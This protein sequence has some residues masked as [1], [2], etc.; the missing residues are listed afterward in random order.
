MVGMHVYPKVLPHYH[1]KVPDEFWTQHGY[2][3]E[4]TDGTNIRFMLYDER[5]TYSDVVTDLS[6]SDGDIVVGTRGSIRGLLSGETTDFDGALHRIVSRLREIDVEDIR[7]IHDEYNSPVVWFAEGMVKHSL[8]YE[9]ADDPPP[10]VLGFDVYVCNDDT[11]ETIPSNP[12]KHTFDGFVDTLES[13][14]LFGRIGVPF[15]SSPNGYEK[16]DLKTFSPETYTI[17]QS[18]YGNLT[19]EGIVIRAPHIESY[20]RVKVRSEEFEEKNKDAMGYREDNAETP[21]EHFVALY[22]TEERIRKN[23]AKLT[24]EQGYEFDRGLIEPLW[25]QVYNDIWEE[26]YMDIKELSFA[27]TP[28]DTKDIVAKRVAETIDRLVTNAELN[29]TNPLNIWSSLNQDS[30]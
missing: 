11:R 19:A 5:F 9:Y 8:D 10:A 3:T 18:A 22:C 6:P 12:V 20:P 4:K 14:E 30:S 1:P 25:K 16:I 21:E 28:T 24:V 17:P 26:E 13:K 27:F 2:L 15:V 7:Q 23:A 29:D